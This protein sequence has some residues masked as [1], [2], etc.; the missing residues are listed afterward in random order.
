[1]TLTFANLDGATRSIMLDEFERDA[2]A[3]VLYISPQLNPYGR[4]Q[5]PFLLRAALASS[6]PELLARDLA[7]LA[8]FNEFEAAP[9]ADGGSPT[10]QSV[11]VDA[12]ATLAETEFNRFYA[13]AVCRRALQTD[14]HGVVEVYVAREGAAP[15]GTARDLVGRTVAAGPLLA[16]LRTGVPVSAALGLD[17][18]NA[19]LSVS[20]PSAAAS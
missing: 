14:P 1:M 7:T 20:L 10:P 12:G 18:P 15:A 9:D 2:A 11:P 17:D 6:V 16:T 3:N 4:N 19:A 8:V 13:R 5:W